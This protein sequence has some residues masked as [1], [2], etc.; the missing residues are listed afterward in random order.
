MKRPDIDLVCA[1][2]SMNR[3]GFAVLHYSAA[4]Q[5]VTVLRKSNVNNKNLAGNARK[6][7]GQI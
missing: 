4:D 7:H 6:P 3:P 2:L 1:D 5:S